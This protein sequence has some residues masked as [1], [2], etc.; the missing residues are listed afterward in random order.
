MC[1]KRLKALLPVLVYSLER[2]VTFILTR[3]FALWCWR[4]ALRLSIVHWQSLAQGN[5]GVGKPG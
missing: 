5:R 1:G 4:Q 2:Q 3:Q